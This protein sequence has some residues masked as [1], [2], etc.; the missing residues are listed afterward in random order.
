MN[1]PQQARTMAK[2]EDPMLLSYKPRF[3][4]GRYTSNVKERLRISNS[5]W[6]QHVVAG[7][8]FEVDIRS[9]QFRVEFESRLQ[10]VRCQRAPCDGLKRCSKG[11]EL[12]ES[13]S[14]TCS[15]FVATELQKVTATL[16]ESLYQR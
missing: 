3:A 4:C 5:K 16:F 7:K 14:H 13:Q 11:F 12:I 1:C 2:G 9:G 6:L 8:K 10:Q 15:H